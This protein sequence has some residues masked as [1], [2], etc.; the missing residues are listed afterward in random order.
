MNYDRERAMY[1]QECTEEM[2]RMRDPRNAIRRCTGPH[3]DPFEDER[4]ELGKEPSR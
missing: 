3:P 4:T 2:I 1:E